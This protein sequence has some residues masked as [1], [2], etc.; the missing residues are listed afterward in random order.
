MSSMC[1]G[2]EAHNRRRRARTNPLEGPRIPPDCTRGRG[3]A[4]RWRRCEEP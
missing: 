3:G 2:H 4:D 1:T